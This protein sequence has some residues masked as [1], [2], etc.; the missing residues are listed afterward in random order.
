MIRCPECGTDNPVQSRFCGSCGTRLITAKPPAD[1]DTTAIRVPAAGIQIGGIYAGR[2]MI[3]EALGRGGMGMI[4]KAEDTKLRRTV[5]LKLLPPDLTRDPEARLRFIQEAQAASALEHAN[6]CT[7]YEIDETDEGQMYI[8]MAYYGGETLKAKIEKGPLAP[9]EAVN[10]AVQLARGLSRTHEAGIIHRD[11]KP[12]NIVVTERQEVRIL[13]FGLAKLAG[14]TGVTKTGTTMG[15]V[16]YMSPEQARGQD[17]DHRT[18]IWALGVVLYEM[19]TG[20]L[21]F[22]GDH[23]QTVIYSI[24][25]VEPESTISVRR[26]VPPGLDHIVRKALRKGLEERYR[27]VDDML[28]DL[29]S[30]RDELRTSGVTRPIKAVD[31]AST[32]KMV[33]APRP[34]AVITFDNQTGEDKYDYLSKAIPNLLITSLEQSRFLQVVTWERLRDLL[35]KIGRQ[36][37]E[38]ID[39]DLG[40]ELCVAEGIDSIVVGSFTK[41]GNM[42][43]TDVKVLD[44]KTKQLV[45]ST[46]SR[47]D[48]V[49]SILHTQIDELSRGIIEGVG[50]AERKDL[51]LPIAEVTTTSMDAYD[52]FLRGRDAYERLYNDEARQHLE[53]AVELDCTFAVAYLYLAWVHSRLRDTKA[54]NMAYEKAKAFADKATKKERMYIEAAYALSIERATERSFH[55]LRQMAQEFPQE[56]RVHHLLAARYR[57]KGLFYQAIEEYDR[58]LD[59]DPSYSWAINE[60]AYMYTDVGD[61]EKAQEYFERNRTLYPEDAN[62]IDSMGELFFRMGNIDDAVAMYRQALELKPDF[63]YAYWEIAYVSA[64]KEDY[65][66][67]LRWI[68]TYIE[69]A[70]SFGTKADGH[71][72]KSFYLLWRLDTDGAL[73][74]AEELRELAQDAGSRLY[75]TAAERLRG[76]IHYQ[77]G[78]FDESRRCF[79]ACLE[80]IRSDPQEFAPPE[81]SYSI[82]TPDH[83]PTITAAYIFA[84]GLVDL[85]Q[86]LIDTAR[87][88]LTEVRHLQP[89]YADILHGE[90]L[91]VE[92]AY[93]RAIAVLERASRWKL[94]YMSDIDGMLAYNLPPLSDVLARAYLAKGDLDRANAEYMRLITMD[95]RKRDRQ[96]IHPLYHLRLAEVYQAKKWETRA[97]EERERFA[98]LVGGLDHIPGSILEAEQAPGKVPPRGPEGRPEPKAET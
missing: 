29:L 53:K 80:A 20:R 95:P 12:A 84:V 3:V 88:R 26:D 62:P 35:G 78:Q 14:Q 27:N 45:G 28:A 13:D 9:E 4:Y 56:K 58:V 83:I 71:I 32:S 38:V 48:G 23:D 6:I 15:T 94:P 47:G 39:K 21:P 61:F 42:F 5:A 16:L 51:A 90:L 60:I 40:F 52:Y 64:L 44:V 18:D 30:I 89:N 1:T 76:W 70:P 86:G 2:Y 57:V 7:I 69:K 33:V 68:D 93:D 50:I 72:W 74:E 85:K 49:D 82:W 66:S 24:L 92:G 65:A 91:L 55:I 43:A 34:I 11:I 87:F 10:V 96:L 41:A 59:L 46:S 63:Y 22:R 31:R 25:N 75:A 79:D 77:L 19:V 98:D 17:V 36:D 73:A 8:A 67:A 54:R 37:A 81:T 97:T